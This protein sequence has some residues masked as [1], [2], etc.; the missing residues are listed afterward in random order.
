MPSSLALLLGEATGFLLF[1]GKGIAA[2]LRLVLVAAAASVRAV[3]TGRHFW[4]HLNEREAG[5]VAES[6]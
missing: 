5:R 1:V 4:E 3:V 6:A 2:P